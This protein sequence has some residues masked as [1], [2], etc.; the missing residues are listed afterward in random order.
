MASMPT[1][2]LSAP[3]IPAHPI[4]GR[5][6][7][8][9]YADDLPELRGLLKEVLTHDGHHV[10]TVSDGG[11]ALERLKQPLGPFDLLIT[12]HHM[13]GV[14]GLDLVRQTRQLAYPGKIVVFSSELSEDVMEQYRQFDVDAILP[15]PIFPRTFRRVLA[16]LFAAERPPSGQEQSAT[17]FPSTPG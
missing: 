1:A 14:N 17:P 6:L 12:D 8:I 5:M 11:E 4:L 13:P 15:K 16:Q 9:L 3:A 7:R 10:E 2:T